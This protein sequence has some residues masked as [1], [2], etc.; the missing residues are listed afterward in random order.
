MIISVFMSLN[1]L[2]RY[3]IGNKI[4]QVQS[5]EMIDKV[6]EYTNSQKRH[7]GRNFKLQVHNTRK[8]MEIGISKIGMSNNHRSKCHNYVST[9]YESYQDT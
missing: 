2:Y 7:G 6:R 8:F 3:S 4:E 1:V 5:C 9:T